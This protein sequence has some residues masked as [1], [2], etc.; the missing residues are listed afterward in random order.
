MSDKKYYEM[1]VIYDDVSKKID[2]F[3]S[4]LKVVVARY[5]PESADE[6]I[7]FVSQAQHSV[8]MLLKFNFATFLPH[9][10]TWF[11]NWSARLNLKIIDIMRLDRAKR[12][13]MLKDIVEHSEGKFVTPFDFEQIAQILRKGFSKAEDKRQSE[14]IRAEIRVRFKTPRDFLKKYTEDISKGGIFVKTINPLPVRTPVKIL[15]EVPGFEGLELSGSVVYVLKEEE[16]VKIGRSPGN[17]V[18]FQNLSPEQSRKLTEMVEKLKQKIFLPYD[19]RRQDERVWAEIKLKFKS[20]NGFIKEYAE[21]ISKGGIFIRTKKPIPFNTPVKILLE[22]PDAGSIEL[23][24]R[25][26]YI[27]NEEEAK[28]VMRNPGVGV[29][30]VDNPPEIMK[31]LEEF[32]EKVKKMKLN[33]EKKK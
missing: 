7:L 14:R 15:L 22:F 26:V 12:E 3:I 33:G 20:I 28:R 19:E 6:I 23:N 25:V 8:Y 30:F 21:D 13:A 9:Y 31:K 11:N 16:A 1:L 4:F 10:F 29:Q 17:G 32:I 2:E 24:G 27:L 5:Y 18:E